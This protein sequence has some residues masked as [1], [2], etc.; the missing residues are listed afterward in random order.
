MALQATGDS[1]VFWVALRIEAH[2]SRMVELAV[3]VPG[4]APFVQKCSLLGNYRNSLAG[5]A[6][7]LRRGWQERDS[8]ATQ[9]TTLSPVAC[10]A[11]LDVSE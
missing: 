2:T 8:R 11:M 1:V 3:P 10:S 4:F 7:K 6:L 9:K 5:F